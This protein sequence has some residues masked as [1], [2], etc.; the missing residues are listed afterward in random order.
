MR[1]CRLLD[2]ATGLCVCVSV[3]TSHHCRLRS[4]DVP[5]CYHIASYP[6]RCRIAGYLAACTKLTSLLAASLLIPPR[7]TDSM[8]GQR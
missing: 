6:A 3:I 7:H 5:A 1:A 4:L 8:S 2:D